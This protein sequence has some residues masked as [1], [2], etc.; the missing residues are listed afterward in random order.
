MCA[1]SEHN[2]LEVIAPQLTCK[3]G[4]AKLASLF[5]DQEQV[6]APVAKELQKKYEQL[7]DA[8]Q[9]VLNQNRDFETEIKDLAQKLDRKEYEF[10]IADNELKSLRQ[11]NQQL[12]QTKFSQ[13]KSITEQM[14]LIQSL[15]RELKDKE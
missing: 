1:C 10:Q 2:S 15:Q 8:N 4:R 6:Y 3:L 12:D 7:T 9:K 14:M 13:E 11:G 5:D